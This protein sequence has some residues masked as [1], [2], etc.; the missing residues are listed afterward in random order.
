MSKLFKGQVSGL[1]DFGERF[2]VVVDAFFECVAGGATW[3]YG[4]LSQTLLHAWVGE[5]FTQV[6]RKLGYD[7]RRRA[8]GHE[9]PAP[10]MRIN[11]G[12]AGLS[13]TGNVR[14]LRGPFRACDCK[15]P[16]FAAL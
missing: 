5:R 14:E 6:R 4:H 15:R 10:K 7:C 16:G 13:H 1:H 11:L 8:R 9:E 12:K 3:G 2:D